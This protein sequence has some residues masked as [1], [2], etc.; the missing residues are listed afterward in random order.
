MILKCT[1]SYL[2]AC[3]MQVF[4][5]RDQDGDGV[6]SGPELLS[7]MQGACGWSELGGGH[8]HGVY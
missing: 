8:L 2:S 4:R 6:I 5:A 3:T 1:E 7:L